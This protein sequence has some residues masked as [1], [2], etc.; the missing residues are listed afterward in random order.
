MKATAKMA[1]LW[2]SAWALSAAGE[3]VYYTDF[4]EWVGSDSKYN[5][6]A[7]AL[8]KDIYTGTN[9]WY[10][11]NKDKWDYF[12]AR[13]D[14]TNTYPLAGPPAGATGDASMRVGPSGAH[15]YYAHSALSAVFEADKDYQFTIAARLALSDGTYTNLNAVG[16]AR[17]AV[18]FY[19][20]DPAT[21]GTY[22]IS[23]WLGD[24]G[25]N[26]TNVSATGWTTYTSRIRARD[27]PALAIGG[28]MY[29]RLYHNLA[30][31]TGYYTSVDFLRIESSPALTD[32]DIWAEQFPL[33]E[34]PDGDDDDDGLS[35][36][37]EFGLG[38][39]PTNAADQGSLPTY[40]VVGAGGTNWFECVHPVSSNPESD[41][42]YTLVLSENLVFG[43]WTNAGYIAT[44]TNVTGGPLNYV[45]NRVPIATGDAKFMHLLIEQQ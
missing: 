29:V 35:N 24:A 43:G 41:L 20:E 26:A 32:F 9:G 31:T 44:G 17:L 27:I 39:N 28:R 13:S 30:N 12:V 45:T 21:P 37:Y 34:G 38:G 18:N 19:S 3:V 6:L 36:L 23:S 4:S 14:A 10:R 25:I 40:T 8:A 5:F 22:V 11:S 16:Q 33:S 1:V 2:L 7:Q 15:T 42:G